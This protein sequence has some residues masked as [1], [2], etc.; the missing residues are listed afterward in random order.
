M[1]SNEIEI[2]GLK[3]RELEVREVGRI[4][5]LTVEVMTAALLRYMYQVIQAVH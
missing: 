5:W 3:S 2:F 1:I 4:S